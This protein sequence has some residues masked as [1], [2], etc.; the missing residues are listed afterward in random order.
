MFLHASRSSFWRR[1][2]IRWRR[3]GCRLGCE[4]LHK[5]WMLMSQQDLRSSYPTYPFPWILLLVEFWENIHPWAKGQSGGPTSFFPVGETDGCW[6]GECLDDCNEHVMYGLCRLY[7]LGGWCPTGPLHV[8]CQH[9]LWSGVLKMAMKMGG[10]R[11]QDLLE[12]LSS[13]VKVFGWKN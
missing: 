5:P 10:I 8:S 4:Q 3:W 7:W 13:Q 12:L 11:H 1:Q 2:D 9:Q 6:T